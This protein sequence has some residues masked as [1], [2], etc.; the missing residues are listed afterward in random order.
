MGLCN[1]SGQA[2][3]H[4]NQ[5]IIKRV[6]QCV[7]LLL[8]VHRPWNIFP[9]RSQFKTSVRHIQ[10]SLLSS[11]DVIWSKH[12]ATAV[13]AVVCSWRRWHG[14]DK[15]IRWLTGVEAHLHHGSPWP[16]LFRHTWRRRRGPRPLSNLW[17]AP[18]FLCFDSILLRPE[19]PLTLKALQHFA[20][21]PVSCISLLSFRFRFAS[22]KS[23]SYFEPRMKM[24]LF[25]IIII[26]L[27]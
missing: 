16:D 19:S 24:T 3:V 10:M 8:Y 22:Y 14:C 20:L 26:G 17:R 7:M 25:I 18:H 11:Y 21:L 6:I 27:F 2:T 12:N 13:S 5:P 23:Q 1:T 9:H 4:T 15:S